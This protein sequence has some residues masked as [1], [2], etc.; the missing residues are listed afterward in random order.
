[1]FPRRTAADKSGLKERDMGFRR[2]AVTHVLK[3]LLTILCRID[4]REYVKALS[5][6]KPL[7]II[8]NHINFLEVPILITHSYPLYVSG[9]AKSETWDNPLFAFIFN[10]YKAVPI[11]RNGAFHESFRHVHNAI[12]KGFYMCVAPEGTR[13][14][15]GVLGRGKAGI[16]QLALEADVPILPVAHHGGENIWKNIRSLKRTQFHFKAGRPFRINFEGRPNHEEREVIL[17]EV[18][19]QLARLLP[20]RLRGFYSQHAQ[21]DCKYLDFI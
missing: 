13:S 4:C 3:G 12:Q 17:S 10:T 18:M 6:C 7:I 21:S 16:I 8:F 5:N 15:N 2:F 9:L 20:E 1:M 14:K 19:G 11:N